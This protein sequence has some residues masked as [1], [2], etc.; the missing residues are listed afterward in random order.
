MQ[1]VAAIGECM[2]EM[3]HVSGD[4]YVRGFA[5]DTL[6]MAVY[7]ARA[8]LPQ[9]SIS[10]ITALGDDPY[11]HYMLDQWQSEG[12]E[13]NH[14]RTLPGKMPGLYL[15]ET[16]QSGERNLYYYRSN[17]AAK[18]LFEDDV[19]QTLI[20]K[21]FE[22]PVWFFSS[23]TLAILM[24]QSRAR[25]LAAVTKAKAQG[26]KI[27]FDTNYRP[28]LWSS[29]SQAQS[30]IEAILKLANI[31]L[32][33]F[34]DQKS[35]FGDA[36]HEIALARLE[37]YGIEEIVLKMGEQGCYLSE[38]EQRSHFAVEPVKHPVD[39][40]A[41]GDSFDGVY[42]AHRLAGATMLEATEKAA[43]MAAKVIQ[44]HGAIIKK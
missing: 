17:S 11:S 35:L 18:Y 24:E 29:A 14:V 12:I 41:A 25:F 20:N 3:A 26:I 10:Y 9:Q 13:I 19:G 40:T 34:D 42:L 5:G 4:E 44:Y 39:T 38:A 32:V 31:A 6:N 2:V 33:S 8:K 30:H 23:I 15:I 22:F 43:Q 37:R 28:R 1:K 21:L 36:S 27:V 16:D 7:F